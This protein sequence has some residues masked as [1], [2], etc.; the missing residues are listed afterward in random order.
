MIWYCT[1][2]S[3]EVKK[4]Q[5][6]KHTHTHHTATW[7]IFSAIGIYYCTYQLI[8]FITINPT[9]ILKKNLHI[10]ARDIRYLRNQTLPGLI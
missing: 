10:N 7:L 9:R 4:K 6:K 3:G 5:R 2:M 8:T 1:V